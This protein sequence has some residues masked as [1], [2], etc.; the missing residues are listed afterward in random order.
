MRHTPNVVG[1]LLHLVLAFTL[2]G[3]AQVLGLPSVRNAA[4]WQRAAHV[5]ASQRTDDASDG[6]GEIEAAWDRAGCQINPGN[7]T[8]VLLGRA[9]A[10]DMSDR[11]PACTSDADTDGCQ[12]ISEV[13]AGLD[14]LNGNDCLGDAAGTP[15]LNCLFPHSNASCNA[16]NELPASTDCPLLSRDPTCDGFAR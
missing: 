4:A 10:C 11:D 2:V 14:P 8:C 13:L 1:F 16:G 15:L 12:D 7:P 5:D 3:C 9:S 6:T